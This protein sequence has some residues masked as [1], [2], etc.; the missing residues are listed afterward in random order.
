MVGAGLVV[1]QGK[2][3]LAHEVRAAEPL[4]DV[5]RGDLAAEE[6]DARVVGDIGPGHRGVVPFGERLRAAPVGDLAAG[7]VAGVHGV[8][9]A[10]DGRDG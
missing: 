5:G 4:A 3:F 1:G 9:A 7:L 2:V 8:V 10:G 6:R